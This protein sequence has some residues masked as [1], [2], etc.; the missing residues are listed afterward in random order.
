[1]QE[2]DSPSWYN[3][4]EIVRV[5]SYLSTLYNEGLKNDDIGIVTP[6]QKQV[7]IIEADA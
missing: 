5:V 3:D 6:Y 2:E 7:R 4:H 1:M